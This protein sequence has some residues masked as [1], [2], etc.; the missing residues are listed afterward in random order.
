MQIYYYCSYDGSPSGYHIGKVEDSSYNNELQ[1]LSSDKI[2]PFIRQC[3][4]HG[5]VRNGFG[6]IPD[7]ENMQSQYFLLIKRLSIVKNEVRY[8]I[9]LAIVTD[10]WEQFEK[11]M[12]KENTEERIAA[13][14]LESMESDNHSYFGYRIYTDRIQK[15]SSCG[16]GEI[17]AYKKQEYMKEIEQ[18]KALFIETSVNGNEIEE[19]ERKLGLI[20]DKNIER[21]RITERLFCYKKKKSALSVQLKVISGVVI[22]LLIILLWILNQIPVKF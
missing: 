1:E 18:N 2:D 20:K 6:R 4:E 13:E 16:Y 11:L 22:L 15:I 3:F 12:R 8:Y 19:L 9:N 10:R 5:T 17:F 21:C 7:N 14:I